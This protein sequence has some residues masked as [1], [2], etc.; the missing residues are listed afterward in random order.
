M[1]TQ[2]ITLAVIAEFVF[3]VFRTEVTDRPA[4]KSPREFCRIYADKVEETEATETMTSMT[5]LGLPSLR[6][7]KLTYRTQHQEQILQLGDYMLDHDDILWKVVERTVSTARTGMALERTITLI[8]RE[9]DVHEHQ[10]LKIPQR[11]TLR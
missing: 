4:K 10:H 11:E 8:T 7:Q 9:V 3:N 1:Q 5:S 6:L 2:S